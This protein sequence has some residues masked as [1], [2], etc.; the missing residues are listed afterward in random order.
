MNELTET[1]LEDIIFEAYGRPVLGWSSNYFEKIVVKLLTKRIK[2]DGAIDF[3]D[4]FVS[5]KLF[6][7]KDL[8]NEAPEVQT[9]GAGKSLFVKLI[10]S[11]K[12]KKSEA[13]KLLLGIKDN[14]SGKYINCGLL[15]N[16]KFRSYFDIGTIDDELAEGDGTLKSSDPEL[17]EDDNSEGG[18]DPELA[19]SFEN[20][21]LKNI[22]SEGLFK[23][24]K[25]FTQ[26][27]DI[28]DKNLKK[29]IEG[30]LN[31][32]VIFEFDSVQYCKNFKKKEQ[33]NINRL[34][35]MTGTAY[36][37]FNDNEELNITNEGKVEWLQRRTANMDPP[38]PI[39]DEIKE[40]WANP[41]QGYGLLGLATK[42]LVGGAF[43][44]MGG[45]SISFDVVQ[46]ESFT[47]S[48]LNEFSHNNMD[49]QS[50]A[51]KKNKSKNKKDPNTKFI[52]QTLSSAS[53]SSIRWNTEH[54]KNNDTYE[55]TATDPFEDNILKIN[56]KLK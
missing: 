12:L 11:I 35:G 56:F 33:F 23:K 41:N 30:D 32:S 19:E 1:Y 50:I 38:K 15:F 20:I 26:P 22:I 5:K 53:G 54:I 21:Y 8:F 46:N 3:N 34:S 39:K 6:D 27:F 16:Q 17:A 28:N 48:F 7:F 45:T 49:G 43:H 36:M 24:Q 13:E 40:R 10:Y 52:K 42:K 9:S 4:F 44:L 47:I 51:N 55:C 14:K 37:Q 29:L 18:S 31:L 25:Q 2:K